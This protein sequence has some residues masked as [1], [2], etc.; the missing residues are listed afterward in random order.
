MSK[1]PGREERVSAKRR[2]AAGE[3]EALSALVEEVRGKTKRV[4]ITYRVKEGEV[5]AWAASYE[6]GRG[7]EMLEGR[8]GELAQAVA[9][10]MVEKVDGSWGEIEV[11]TVEGTAE[12]GEVGVREIANGGATL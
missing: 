9:Q 11:D 5:R 4:A 10:E 1:M 3:R 7:W 12:V 6:R 2:Y 8:V